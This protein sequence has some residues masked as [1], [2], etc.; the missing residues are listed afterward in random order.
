MN[1][2]YCVT[3]NSSNSTTHELETQRRP[4]RTSIPSM[5]SMIACSRLRR[6]RDETRPAWT[7]PGR[8]PASA[9][10]AE[11][12]STSPTRGPD[13]TG[14]RSTSI[15]ISVR[16]TEG[17]IRSSPRGSSRKGSGNG[18]KDSSRTLSPGSSGPDS[19]GSV[20]AAPVASAVRSWSIAGSW[21]AARSGSIA[22]SWSIS[23]DTRGEP[24]SGSDHRRGEASKVL[25][26][27]PHLTHPRAAWS[28]VRATRNHVRHSGQQVYTSTPDR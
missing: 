22:R 17:G 6:R 7:R 4:R 2:A 27:C 13:A 21:S 19:S 12:W 8:G 25:R 15:S 10:F 3:N 28:C 5:R 20:P 23:Q 26:H 11:T 18:S 16:E 24:S 9:G 1:Q 14:S